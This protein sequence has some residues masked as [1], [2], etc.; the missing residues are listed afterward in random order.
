MKKLI[1]LLISISLLL[2]FLA[3]VSWVKKAIDNPHSDLKGKNESEIINWEKLTDNIYIN[4][5]SI[6]KTQYTVS[7]FF[8]IYNSEKHKLYDIEGIPVYYELIKYEAYCKENV[9]CLKHIKEFDK[10]GNLLSDEQNNY[11]VCPNSSGYINGE[12][13]HKALCK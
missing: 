8:K 1:R 3:L 2:S 10:D 4:K 5:N 12:I 7:A 13:M 6:E 9:L 11:D